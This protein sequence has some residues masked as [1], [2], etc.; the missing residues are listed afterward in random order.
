MSVITICMRLVESVPGLTPE[1]LV[2]M[3]YGDGSS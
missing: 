1:A 2:G 3:R